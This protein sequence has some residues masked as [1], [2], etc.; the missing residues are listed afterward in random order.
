MIKHFVLDGNGWIGLILYTAFFITKYG[1]KKGVSMGIDN[2]WFDLWYGT[3]TGTTTQ[4]HDKDYLVKID[5]CNIIH[6][7]E[8]TADKVTRFRRA[9]AVIREDGLSSTEDATLI[10]F[11]CGKGRV[12]ILAAKYGFN[13]IIGVELSSS[14][15]DICRQNIAIAKVKNVDLYEID[16]VEFSVPC[17]AEVCVYYFYNPFSKVVLEKVINNIVE[18]YVSKGTSY[19]V[20]S[21][22]VHSEVLDVDDFEC[23]FAS[24]AEKIKVYRIKRH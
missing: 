15:L 19:I 20:Y 6:A 1:V 18:N 16:A 14:M 11:G 5:S 8:S 3:S 21:N 12:L 13:R 2:K 4:T 10:D 23:L 7:V 17:D 9:M 22:P 24:G